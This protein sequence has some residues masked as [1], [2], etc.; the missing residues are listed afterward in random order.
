MYVELVRKIVEQGV[1]FHAARQE[2]TRKQILKRIRK[3]IDRTSDEYRKSQPKI[4]YEDALCR[5]GYLYR[6][7]PA[8]ATLFRHVL[9]ESDEVSDEIHRKDQSTVNILA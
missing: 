7:V 6:N 2:K 8:N 5:L 3:H 1:E 4:N 9:A